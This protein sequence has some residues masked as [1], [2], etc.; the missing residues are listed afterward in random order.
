MRKHLIILLALFVL[1]LTS[2]AQD[3]PDPELSPFMRALSLI[4]DTALVRE[5]TPLF[6]YADY[7]AALAARGIERPE[8]LVAFLDDREVY[9]PI[10]PALPLSGP[11]NLITYLIAGGPEYLA[12]VGFDFFEVSQGVQVGMP[13]GAGQILIGGFSA[14]AVEAAYTARGYTVEREGDSGALLCPAAGCDSGAQIDFRNRLPGNPFGGDLGRSEPV[15][16]DDGVL[17]NSPHLPMVEAM[18]ATYEGSG[19]SL[20]DAP[21]FQA[22]GGVLDDYPY[23][24]SVMAVSP[25][26]LGTIDARIA[27]TP[28]VVQTITEQLESMPVPPY[29]MA[30]F[31]ATAD[32]ENEYG[33]ALLVYVNAEDAQAAAAS[34]DARL[35][36]MES[37]RIPGRTYADLLTDIGTLEP[38]SVVN[39]EA[40]GLSVVV[41]RALNPVPSNEPGDD[42]MVRGS[43]LL[44]RRFYEMIISRDN[45]WLIWGS[46]EE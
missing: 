23:V 44:F 17:L 42:G 1:T 26:S 33:L 29:Q 2:V 37:M 13:P 39:D 12:T 45:N 30:A 3:A 21:E 25:L 14:D 9:G 41:V 22:V 10:L 40:T 16:V 32:P 15:F 31:A 11:E 28:S 7:H 36:A 35:A 43:H 8:R 5:A 27:E 34:I 4:P 46:G 20:A 18:A 6:S 38:A 19:A 24:I